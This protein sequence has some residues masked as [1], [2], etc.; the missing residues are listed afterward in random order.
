MP[1][2]NGVD[3]DEH[4]VRQVTVR[5]DVVEFRHTL[6]IQYND[7][8]LKTLN[9][10]YDDADALCDLIAELQICLVEAS[11]IYC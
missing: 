6:T 1:I 7:G 10:I 5:F 3:I 4:N 9:K 11:R 8:E 2:I